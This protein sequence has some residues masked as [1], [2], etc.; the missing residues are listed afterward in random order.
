[1]IGLTVWFT[2][3][4]G[5][6]KSTICRAVYE[7]LTLAGL[8]VEILD[9]DDLRKNL[10]RDLR[11]SKEDRDENVH[12]IGFVAH[13]LAKHGVIVLVA[14]ISPYK[15]TRDAVRESCGNFLEVY[16]N[17]PLEVCEE[18]DVKGLYAKARAG[19]L[20]NLTGVDD[21]YE[22]AERPEVECR[23]G[24]ETIEQSRDKVLRAV[25]EFHEV[26]KF[27]SGQ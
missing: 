1:M 23:T 26:H 2:G 12:R 10:T 11:F 22:P 15:A 20:W 18:R 27:Y 9:G 25:Y 7:E 24:E 4:S 13:L 6:G 5:S 16:V 21:P 19:E 14:V 3:L 8:K 17:A